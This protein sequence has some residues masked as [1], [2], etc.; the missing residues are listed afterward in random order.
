[1]RE[2][3]AEGSGAAVEAA[4]M[5]WLEKKREFLLL[6]SSS[7][8]AALGTMNCR[9]PEGVALATS[10]FFSSVG[11]VVSGMSEMAISLRAGGGSG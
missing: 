7:G 4:R 5:F 10:V 11:G 9:F 3:S 8:R 6:G 2:G 1:M